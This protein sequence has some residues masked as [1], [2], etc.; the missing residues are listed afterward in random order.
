[1]VLDEKYQVTVDPRNF[2]LQKLE[3]VTDKKT[4]EVVRQDY[5]NVGYFW[6][7]EHLLE[8]YATERI[9]EQE[10]TSIEEVKE[11]ILSLHRTIERVV[12]K[13]SIKLDVYQTVWNL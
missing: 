7:F 9:R 10:N 12:K 8:R 4:K 11:L 13:E 5:K 3:D 2:I 6:K 1:M